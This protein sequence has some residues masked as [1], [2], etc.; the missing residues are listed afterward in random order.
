M[1]KR[2]EVPII[3]IGKVKVRHDRIVVEYKEKHRDDQPCKRF[4]LSRDLPE[5][6]KDQLAERMGEI[7]RQAC[8]GSY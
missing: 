2:K 6:G 4:P 3:E 1:E 8:D 5:C 7:H